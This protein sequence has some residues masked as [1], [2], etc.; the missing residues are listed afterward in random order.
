MFRGVTRGVR[1]APGYT[2]T[3][4]TKTKMYVCSRYLALAGSE[5][6]YLVIREG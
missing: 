1:T 3:W 4:V 5:E 2:I 6:V